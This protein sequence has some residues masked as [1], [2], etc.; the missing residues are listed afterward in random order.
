VSSLALPLPERPLGPGRRWPRL[1]A[2]ARD[3]RD[4]AIALAVQ[5]LEAAAAVAARFALVDFGEVT[6]AARPGELA[7]AFARGEM[8]ED[9]PGGRI[10]AAAA[11]ERRARG[12]EVGDA[13]RWGVE[14][15]LR[16]AER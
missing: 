14:R 13:C 11:A 10:L 6:L 15:L 5:G 1:G 9:E 4:A 16:V 7:R 2:Q 8:G 3:E 12:G